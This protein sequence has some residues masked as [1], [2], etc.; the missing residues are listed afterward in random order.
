MCT[1]CCSSGGWAPVGAKGPVQLDALERIARRGLMA[2]NCFG[3]RVFKHK[4]ENCQYAIGSIYRWCSQLREQNKLYDFSR[5]VSVLSDLRDQARAENALR[6]D[7][8]YQ[9]LWSALSIIVQLLGIPEGPLP[10]LVARHLFTLLSAG[11][12]HSA[13]SK[14][15][16]LLVREYASGEFKRISLEYTLKGGLRLVTVAHSIDTF[17]KKTLIQEWKNLMYLDS[18]SSTKRHG[19]ESYIEA[20]SYMTDR[21]GGKGARLRLAT[22]FYNMG[23]L[24]SLIEGRGTGILSTLNLKQ[25]KQMVLGMS[26]DLNFIHQQGLVHR[27]L[28]PNNLVVNMAGNGDISS[29]WIDLSSAVSSGKETDLATFGYEPP[30]LFTTEDFQVSPPLAR[31][32]MDIYSFGLV[33]LFTFYSSNQPSLRKF[34]DKRQSILREVALQE[35]GKPTHSGTWL[36]WMN[37]LRRDPKLFYI[38]ESEGTSYE[39]EDVVDD[40][41]LS[42]IAT[43]IQR[44][45]AK[46]PSIATVHSTLYGLNKH[47]FYFRGPAASPSVTKASQARVAT[48]PTG[49]TVDSSDEEDVHD[50]MDDLASPTEEAGKLL[51]PLGRGAGLAVSYGS[52]S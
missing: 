45:P 37:G 1:V 36:A 9:S 42:L 18:A 4:I 28:N 3:C 41:L 44:D 14:S 26:R 8:K 10:P 51:A 32:T 35:S 31:K 5:E 27:D 39:I 30:E 40:P 49:V 24:E 47:S 13:H 19:G 22:P 38:P 12:A 11:G 52:S 43:M 15:T 23:S 16:H 7:H 46:R 21:K 34:F 20:C 50:F 6:A 29:R 17:R 33:L 2:K 25:L 48:A